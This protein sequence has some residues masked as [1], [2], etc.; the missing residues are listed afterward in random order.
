MNV[1]SIHSP[2]TA[3]V[4]GLVT[5]FHCVGMCGPL[6][7]WLA[8][9]TAD[10]GAPVFAV[11]QGARLVSYTA[12]GALM[13]LVGYW[14]I[15]QF[16]RSVGAILPWILVLYF[17]AVA[18]RLDRRIRKPLFAVRLGLRVQSWTRG[19]SP[20]LVAAGLGGATPLLPCG[21][22]YFVVTLAALSGSVV[23]G[24]EFML[25]FGFGTLPLLWLAQAQFG[26]IRGRLSPVSMQRLQSALALA[27]AAVISWRLVAVPGAIREHVAQWICF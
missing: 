24:A 15:A 4:A 11:Y 2:G 14:P 8:P 10:D 13:G 16:P 23:R 26:R 6:A 1:T 22:L 18:F 19:K 17:V 9:K 12:L 20:L 5:S 27:A 3:F 25:A 7:C 21:P